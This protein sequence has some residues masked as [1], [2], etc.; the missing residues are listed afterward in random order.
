MIRG[1]V[2]FRLAEPKPAL[3]SKEP[4][5]GKREMGISI[6][7]RL[8]K[9][10]GALIERITYWHFQGGIFVGGH[11]YESDSTATNSATNL[12]KVELPRATTSNIMIYCN[13][14]RMAACEA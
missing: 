6:P 10:K 8:S 12:D 4:G 1:G 11:V 5:K 14:T 3:F 7:R 9:P 13:V 2:C